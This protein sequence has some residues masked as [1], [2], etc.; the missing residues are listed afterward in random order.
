VEQA[1]EPQAIGIKWIWGKLASQFT[2]GLFH[3]VWHS[4]I[5][6]ALH[7]HLNREEVGID[8]LQIQHRLLDRIT[9]AGGA[10]AGSGARGRD[11]WGSSWF[12]YRASS[13]LLPIAVLLLQLF[14]YPASQGAEG[15]QRSPIELLLLAEAGMLSDQS[16]VFPIKPL[17]IRALAGLFWHRTPLC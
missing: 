9:L 3:L 11:A 17:A 6:D 16:I 1:V 8:V 10:G 4:H 13:W 12:W 15:L 7:Q 2:K 14:Q 5:K